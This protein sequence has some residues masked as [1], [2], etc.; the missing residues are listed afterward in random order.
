VNARRGA[1]AVT[2]AAVATLLGSAWVAVEESAATRAALFG[3]GAVL[4]AIVVARFML[5]VRRARR[6]AVTA[7]SALGERGRLLDR[8]E[9]RYRQL[10]EQVP[11]VVILF[12][13]G[14]KSGGL[15]PVYVSPQALAIL[16]VDPADWLRD[17]DSVGSRIH[18]DD[19]VNL[20]MK[21]A[22]Q[23]TGARVSA[24]EFRYTHPDG[25]EIWLRDVSG[26]VTTEPDG[27]YLQAML[28][29]ITEAKRA[30]HERERME[31]ELRLAQRLEAVGQ[32]ASGIAHE[33][34][35]PIQFVGDTFRFLEGA[36]G[37]LLELTAIQAELRDAAAAGL[38]DPELLVRVRAA[39]E[40][41]DLGYLREHVPG[42]FL[43]GIHG[44]SRVATI[45]R[46]MRD[47]AYSSNAERVPTDVV[48][49][50]NTTL[51]VATNEYRY[52]ADLET[53]FAAVP[54]VMGNGGELQQVFLNLVVNAAHAIESVVGES[55]G[56][57]RITVSASHDGDDV[58]VSI[59]DTGCG[60][61][62][63]VAD[64]VFDPFFTTKDVGRGT[65]Q[66]LA[67]ARTMI[68][69]G[70]GGTLTF[71]TEPGVG[72]TFHVRLPLISPART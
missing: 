18:P 27:R 2:A 16:G 23:A 60:I 19:L 40:I 62:A 28:V 39:E 36:F 70:H 45:V 72:T 13:L 5:L 69:E 1:V 59:A 38:V 17:P 10:V 49:A 41:A 4:S 25:R 37:D 22:Q 6:L 7:E 24:A 12:A 26:V 51:V 47:Y 54:P 21:L 53:E 34:N 71:D 46:A 58:L 9:A 42:A 61:P 32:L 65:G 63:E 35:T 52:V 31:G 15:T 68:V 43:R 11:A 20:Q 3:G 14:G 56:R 66:G 50:L 64:R 29:D 44:I 48:G 8:S 67:L 33:I 30:E 57:G 55:G